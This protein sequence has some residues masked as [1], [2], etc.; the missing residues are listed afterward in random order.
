LRF[1]FVLKD[2][3]VKAR[4]KLL[5]DDIPMNVTAIIVIINEFVNN[6][7][8]TPIICPIFMITINFAREL[9]LPATT[10]INLRVYQQ[11]EN[12]ITNHAV[13]SDMSKEMNISGN[14]EMVT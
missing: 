7:N 6:K 4:A 12:M 5:P 9:N 11:I 8:T 13:D 3:N 2:N 1:I 14:Y 10:E